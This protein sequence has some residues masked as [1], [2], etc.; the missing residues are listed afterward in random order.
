MIADI[1]ART[2]ATVGH[3]GATDADMGIARNHC[4]WMHDGREAFAR[5]ARAFNRRRLLAEAV[6]ACDSIDEMTLRPTICVLD[7]TDDWKS[8]NAASLVLGQIIEKSDEFE[9]RTRR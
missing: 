5:C 1:R 9:C 7:F 6:D 8:E 3:D 2:D 4:G